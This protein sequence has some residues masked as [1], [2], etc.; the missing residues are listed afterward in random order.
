MY[1]QMKSQLEQSEARKVVLGK[2][3]FKLRNIYITLLQNL[4]QIA[5]FKQILQDLGKHYSTVNAVFIC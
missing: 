1:Y 3:Q 5:D 2:T 4:N